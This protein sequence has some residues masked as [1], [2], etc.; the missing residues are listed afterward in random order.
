MRGGQTISCAKRGMLPMDYIDDIATLE[1]LYG[2]PSAVSVRKVVHRLTPLYRDWIMASRFC[3]VST[4]GPAGTDGSP[5]W[6]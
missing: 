1:A 5:A 6:R 4:V 2:A 3:I